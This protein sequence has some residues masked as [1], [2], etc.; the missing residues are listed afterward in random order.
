MPFAEASTVYFAFPLTFS[1]A[2]WNSSSV[3]PYSAMY[4][5][6]AATSRRIIRSSS[7]VY[8]DSRRHLLLMADA[9]ASKHFSRRASP[10]LSLLSFCGARLTRPQGTLMWHSPLITFPRTSLLLTLTVD[11]H[12]TMEQAQ[13]TH[14]IPNSRAKCRLAKLVPR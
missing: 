12:R 2:A 14:P 13:A 4:C 7:A 11:L 6:V 8:L 10:Q 9:P 5:F 3:F 1:A